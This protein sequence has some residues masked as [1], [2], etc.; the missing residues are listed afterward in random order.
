MVAAACS[1]EVLALV[2]HLRLAGLA[3][4]VDDHVRA[5]QVYAAVTAL[6]TREGCS[7]SDRLRDAL[8]AVLVRSRDHGDAFARA[9]EVVFAPRG[10]SAGAG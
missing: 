1:A 8:R 3:L 2:E 5:Q 6:P 7:S 9:F 10:L 4:G